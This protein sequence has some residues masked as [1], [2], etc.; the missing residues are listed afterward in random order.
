MREELDKVAAKV[1][2]K[3]SKTKPREPRAITVYALGPKDAENLIRWMK[4]GNMVEDLLKENMELR[5]K[6][7]NLEA[8]LTILADRIAASKL[9]KIFKAA[10]EVNK[11]E[12]ED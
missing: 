10:R 11:P 3:T 12:G 7:V 6:Y 5:G 4:E 2:E 1:R 8:K 9:V